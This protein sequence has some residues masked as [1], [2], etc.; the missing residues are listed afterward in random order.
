MKNSIN[1]D[2][3]KLLFQWKE[4]IDEYLTDYLPF[5]EIPRHL[6]IICNSKTYKESRQAI[7]AEHPVAVF[8]ALLTLCR[9]LALIE[10]VDLSEEKPD[11]TVT[12]SNA[13]FLAVKTLVA[14]FNFAR[15]LD[16]DMAKPL[17]KYSLKF[18]DA[19]K[20]PR[21]TTDALDKVLDEI[22]VEHFGIKGILP[23]W[24]KV[25]VYLEKLANERHPVIQE[26][27]KD[28][29]DEGRVFWKGSDE[30]TT[31][32]RIRERLTPIRKKYSTNK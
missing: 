12:L 20:R 13:I 29:E 9:V 31:F 21:D 32:R 15:A 18:M 14:G 2:I 7:L 10:Y 6:D 25:L 11:E 27:E 16:E 4:Q 3:R 1:E 17:V 19:G 22:V 8:D 5:E 24:R 30:P 23:N 26:V 28:N